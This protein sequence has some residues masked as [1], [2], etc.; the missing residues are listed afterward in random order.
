MTLRPQRFWLPQASQMAQ[1]GSRCRCNDVPNHSY[2]H[3]HDPII[4]I[5]K[6]LYDMKYEI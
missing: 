1:F 6:T 2:H 5:V 4:L 3:H